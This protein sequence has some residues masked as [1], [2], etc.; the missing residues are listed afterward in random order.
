M[1][2]M[3]RSYVM[4]LSLCGRY[5]SALH[6]GVGALQLHWFSLVCGELADTNA[7]RVVSTVGH[8][9]SARYG[10]SAALMTCPPPSNTCAPPR[11]VMVVFGGTDGTT[12]F[13]DLHCYDFE[14]RTW[15]EVEVNSCPMPR[16]FTS[17]LVLGSSFYV[18]GGKDRGRQCYADLHECRIDTSPLF[19]GPIGASGEGPVEVLCDDT[20]AQKVDSLDSLSIESAP[21]VAGDADEEVGTDSR[22][23]AVRAK[24]ARK[25]KKRSRSE[26]KRK[27]KRRMSTADHLVVKCVFGNEIRRVSLEERRTLASFRCLVREEYAHAVEDADAI[28]VQYRDGDGD[29]ISVRTEPDYALMLESIAASP[30]AT[31]RI[32]LAPPPSARSPTSSATF[33]GPASAA[34]LASISSALSSLTKRS[35][36]P[37]L[38][39]PWVKGDQLG[40]GA[41]GSVHLVMHSDGSLSA[42]KEITL[43][44]I[45]KND[46]GVSELSREIDILHYAQHKNVVQYFGSLQ[47]GSHFLIFMEFVPGGSIRGADPV[48]ACTQACDGSWVAVLPFPDITS[49]L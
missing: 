20:V 36:P 38:S 5:R 6:N 25:E 35:N 45:A 22:E 47:T 19:S 10:H 24:G 26:S 49:F 3:L 41:Y 17:S 46:R 34:H 29:L 11:S 8:S 12:A 7:W 44:S 27:Q 28:C 16:F 2:V 42:L 39:K 43:E 13:F 37:D 33:G 40:R 30:A 15:W 9:P 32:L 31:P 14:T 23:S 21:D 48:W 18:M 4:H 1:P